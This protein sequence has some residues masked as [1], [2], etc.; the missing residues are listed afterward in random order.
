MVQ[1]QCDGRRLVQPRGSSVRRTYIGRHMEK[2]DFDWTNVLFAM[3]KEIDDDTLHTTYLRQVRR[4]QDLSWVLAYNDRLP[5]GHVDKSYEYLKTCVRYYLARKRN[6]R[7]KR[8]TA[9]SVGNASGLSA[10]SDGENHPRED[11]K[12]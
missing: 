7:T 3:R 6:E 11:I 10:T 5:E 8:E 4:S 2:F 12:R 9:A 1:D